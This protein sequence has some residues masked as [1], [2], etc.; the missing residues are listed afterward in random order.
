MLNSMQCSLIHVQF[1][2]NFYAEGVVQ[3]LCNSVLVFGVRMILLLR[4]H[5]LL[6]LLFSDSFRS[7]AMKPPRAAVL[8]GTGVRRTSCA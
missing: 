7:H 2:C 8:D 6:I 1:L 5:T 3:Y 4:A